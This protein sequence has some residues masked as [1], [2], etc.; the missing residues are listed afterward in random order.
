MS[1]NF[2]KMRTENVYEY[3]SNNVKTNCRSMLRKS[4]EKKVG[5][6]EKQP[7]DNFQNKS[8]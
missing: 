6:K 8:L 5:E 7:Q 4:K 1:S 2:G 3:E